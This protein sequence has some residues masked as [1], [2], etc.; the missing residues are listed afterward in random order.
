MIESLLARDDMRASMTNPV[1]AAIDETP[2]LSSK[3]SLFRRAAPTHGGGCGCI[4][5]TA[6]RASRQPG[7]A[8]THGGELRA[9][10]RERCQR[11]RSGRDPEGGKSLKSIA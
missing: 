3:E 2:V 7:Q 11:P 5:K 8:P 1:D 6:V 10:R 4:E 9:A